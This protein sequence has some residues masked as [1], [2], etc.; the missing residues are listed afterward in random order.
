MGV[1]VEHPNEACTSILGVPVCSQEFPGV[2][3]VDPGGRS[4]VPGG[5]TDGAM[6][7]LG[8]T[9]DHAA[10][11]VGKPIEA[12][13]KHFGHNP[14]IHLQ[15]RREA[16]AGPK[17]AGTPVKRVTWHVMSKASKKKA[18]Q[19]R[20][21]NQDFRRIAQNR[22]ARH[23]YDILETFEAG[24]VLSGSEVKS[25]REGRVTLRDTYA[26]ID[27]GEAWLIGMHIPPYSHSAGGFG[28]PDPD[29][30]RK[31]LLHRSQIDQLTG[32]IAQQS[33]TLVPLSLYFRR[34]NAKVEIA[35]AKGR[36]LWDRRAAIAERDAGREAA[37]E[38]A[39]ARR[40]GLG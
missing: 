8:I 33:L 35:L 11:L 40:R 15:H 16:S 36:R 18:T 34:G 30:T 12:V 22:R 9:A 39:N 27:N 19:A 25:L 20:T 24:I 29:R 6:A 17:A 10:G 31:M 4:G 3:L 37:R 14:G 2:H 5:I 13:G 38:M 23:D 28:T 32:K 21:I 26:R 1:G 7:R